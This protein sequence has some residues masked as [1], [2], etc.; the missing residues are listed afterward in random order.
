MAVGY[1]GK[2]D[3]EQFF[4]YT[5]RTASF[6]EQLPY[7]EEL[8]PAFVHIVVACRQ[9]GDIAG[10]FNWLHALEERAAPHDDLC[11]VAEVH[12]LTGETYA[13][14][15]DLRLAIVHYEQASELYARIGETKFQV[16]CLKG[17]GV[18]HRA[19]GHLQEAALYAARALEMAIMAG[20]NRYLIA[21]NYM[22]VGADALC[23]GDLA[24]AEDAFSAA[25]RIFRE[26]TTLL[27]ED[28]T[29]V[30]LLSFA[31]SL[32]RSFA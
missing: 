28:V 31:H 10:T 25:L 6:I 12:Y 22:H 30:P 3:M 2:N 14:L 13:G 24:G 32:I 4:A 26:R 29:R 15:G 27:R 16:W 21:E 19:P 17:L 5:F 9:K 18:T 20:D 1:I 7:S 8:R 23:V 11:A